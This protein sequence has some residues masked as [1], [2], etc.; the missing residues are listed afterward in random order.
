[1]TQAI[2]QHVLDSADI[3]AINQLVLRERDSRDL[4][5]WDV[6]R[7]CFHP[8][9]VVRLSWFNGSGAEFVDAS[10]DMAK[11]GTKA[12]HRLSPVQVQLSAN[13]AL[14]TLAAIIDIPT[15]IKGTELI[16]SAYSR[17]LYRV[18]R[19]D[20]I[21]RIAGFDAVYVRD[22]LT[23]AIPGQAFAVDPAA[24][25][26]FRSSYRLLT[27]VLREQGFDIGDDLP[28]DDQPETVAALMQE[29]YEWAG[30]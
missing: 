13:R 24:L 18:E 27:Y 11:R 4:L 8:D 15:K 23:V 20:E 5:N 7:A 30:L 3:T 1:M 2:P 21:W 29:L 19:R 26:G 10:V 9:S 12:K 17:L 16:M 14:A 28:G 22:E 25:T 6:M